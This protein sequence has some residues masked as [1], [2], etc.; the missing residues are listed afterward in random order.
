MT[1]AILSFLAWMLSVLAPCVLPVLPVILWWSLGTQKRYKPL[2]IV[3][4]TAFFIT[5][6]TVL[7]KASTVLI[8]IPSTVRTS[9]SATIIIFYGITLVF[10]SLRDK[11]SQILRLHNSSSLVDKA[12]QRDWIL[13]DILLWWSLWPIF[14]SCSP[15]YALLLSVVFPKSFA[16]WI[17]YTL[18][19]ALWF[20]LFLLLFV[21]GGRALIKKATWAMRS[22]WRFKKLLW[23]ILVVTWILIATWYMK[24]L[25]IAILDAGFFDVW[26]F[27][28][29]LLRSTNIDQ[30]STTSDPSP[31]I[32][33]T[34]PWAALLNEYYA[35]PAL[36]W[37]DN[38]I[39][40]W[41]YTSLEQL[42]WKVVLIDFWT[43]SCINC[44]RTLKS[45]Q[46]WHRSYAQSWLVIVWIHAPEFQ[47]EKD[48]ANV[49]KAVQEYGLEY[50]VVQDNWFATWKQFNNKYRPAKYIIDKFWNVRYTHF[51]EGAYEETEQVIQYLLG[52]E[53]PIVTPAAYAD[54]TPAQTKETYLWT[55]RYEPFVL[56][57]KEPRTLWQWSLWWER[58]AFP[59]M[60]R[61]QSQTW[62]VTMTFYWSEINLVM[63]HNSR[64]MP[65]EIYIDWVYHSTIS[66]DKTSVYKL[67]SWESDWVH[68]AEI[69]FVEQGAEIYAFTFW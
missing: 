21:Y 4:S 30:T 45:L 60:Q 23:I 20:S 57:K 26:Q 63:W 3:L 40:G 59:E 9:F 54:Y 43:Y 24:K 41:N 33:S 1:L 12:K 14:A 7:L 36:T 38:R 17:W 8:D 2:V 48:P 58:E 64:A 16:A 29:Q 19:Y 15:T 22:D 32:I 65:V 37:L 39:N 67:W 18:L 5:L 62:S 42:K 28:Q 55:A 6:F 35:A 66:V 10:P 53:W 50:P 31:A 56:S 46:A 34:H 27:E 11:I 69:R 49:A 51:G 68:T 61:L 44:V 52:V 13:W 47:F 25:E